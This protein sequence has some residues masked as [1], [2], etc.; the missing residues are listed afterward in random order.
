MTEALPEEEKDE[1]VPGL[2][3]PWADAPELLDQPDWPDWVPD[4]WAGWLDRGGVAPLLGLLALEP[5][6][7]PEEPPDEEGEGEDGREELL[8]PEEPEE[9]LRPPP[10]EKEL[11]L[12]KA[13]APG[14]AMRAAAKSRGRMR[15]RMGVTPNRRLRPLDS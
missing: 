9:L 2:A 13:S 1:A 10:L 4:C 7:Q 8:H 15:R 3:A 11:D 5:E 14:K 12:A 6:D